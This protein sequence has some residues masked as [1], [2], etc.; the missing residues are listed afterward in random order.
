MP[1]TEVGAED[2]IVTQTDVVPALLEPRVQRWTQKTNNYL[3]KYALWL[4]HKG[5]NRVPGENASL[6]TLPVTPE[7]GKELSH[8][9][10]SFYILPPN[11]LKIFSW[12]FTVNA[13]K[14]SKMVQ[15]FEI[16]NT[17]NLYFTCISFVI[18]LLSGL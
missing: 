1:G 12:K 13:Q 2:A 14:E 8:S 6:V 11:V 18:S 5:K 10:H 7:R 4:G 15:T 3:R 16:E 9:S 17:Y